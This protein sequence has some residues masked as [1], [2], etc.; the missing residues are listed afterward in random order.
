[1]GAANNGVA[2]QQVDDLVAESLAVRG[3]PERV[4]YAT[5]VLL[6]AQDFAAEQLYTRAR[7]G[8]ALAA[9]HGFGTVAGLRVS[10][11][12]HDNP[13]IE[14]RVLPGVALDRLGRLVEVRRTQCIHVARWLAERAAQAATAAERVAVTDAVREDV[15]G[16]KRLVFDVFL[17]FAPCAHGRTPAFAAGPFNATDYVVPAR[18]A[19]G[20]EL[21]L[22]LAHATG[23]SESAPKGTLAVP[24]P[25]P[26]RLEALRRE[27]EQLA[28]PAEHA[29]AW[30]L[31]AQESV[32]DA[33]PAASVEDPGRLPLLAEHAAVADWDK[34]LL[35]RVSVPVRQ[36][37]PT[38]FPTLDEA[39]I[40]AIA[41]RTR[42]APGE[43]PEWQRLA[44]QDPRELADN[45]LRPI[46]FNP[47]AWRGAP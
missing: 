2:T 46:V 10:C 4:H 25:R 38:G 6:D 31:W 28:D 24:R 18:L 43:V 44:D 20:F 36:D 23:E 30:R 41:A 19:D 33:W 9:L 40:A 37:S 14:V 17:R 27:V 45:G 5:G 13:E 7:Q 32:L 42:P 39:A 12:A 34:V 8:R 11:P 15:P 3:V 16:E 26:P 47:H 35:A 22:Q 1:M 29:A 21:T